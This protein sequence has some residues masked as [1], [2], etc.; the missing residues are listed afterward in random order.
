ME[1]VLSVGYKF[2]SMVQDYKPRET[3]GK[4]NETES[5]RLS[6]VKMLLR[7]TIARPT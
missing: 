4:G 6:M 7:N 3:P 5:L 2:T 1:K